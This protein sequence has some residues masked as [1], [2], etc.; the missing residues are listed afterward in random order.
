[1]KCRKWGFLYLRFRKIFQLQRALPLT[2]TRSDSPGP[3][4]GPST[5]LGPLFS[6]ILTSIHFH[7]CRLVSNCM[8]IF[9]FFSLSFC[10]FPYFCFCF[11]EFA[12]DSVC[13]LSDTNCSFEVEGSYGRKAGD[14]KLRIRV[15]CIYH[16]VIVRKDC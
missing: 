8:L 7:L 5:A 6:G 14:G 13:L 16:N 11:D 15:L 3:H 2:P 10:L 9:A 4:Q 12:L 1:M